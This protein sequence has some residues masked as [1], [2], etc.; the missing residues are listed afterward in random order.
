MNP[1]SNWMSHVTYILCLYIQQ[2]ITKWTIAILYLKNSP[3]GLQ[4][5]P[6]TFTSQFSIGPMY[7]RV[8]EH[9]LEGQH[10][11]TVLAF[12]I[13]RIATTHAHTNQH[14]YLHTYCISQN[15]GGRKTLTDH[16]QNCLVEKTLSGLKLEIDQVYVLIE[17]FSKT[18]YLFPF[19]TR[20]YS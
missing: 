13:R 15:F 14:L 10:V 20:D 18:P 4:R 12:I 16:C 6:R 5:Y 3:S 7:L 19:L 11:Q 17:C 8:L 1:G 9:T 2:W